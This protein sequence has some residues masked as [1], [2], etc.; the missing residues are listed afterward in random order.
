MQDYID[1]REVYWIVFD[2][3]LTARDNAYK[4]KEYKREAS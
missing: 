2:Y 4:N 1:K 3:S